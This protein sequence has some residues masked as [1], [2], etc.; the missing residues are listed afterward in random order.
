MQN[1]RLNRDYCML[2]S[3]SPIFAPLQPEKI[4]F[5]AVFI[6]VLCACTLYIGKTPKTLLFAVY[7]LFLT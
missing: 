4:I 7:R 5:A 1:D 3:V 2:L 6:Y